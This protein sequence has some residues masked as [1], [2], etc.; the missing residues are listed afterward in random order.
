LYAAVFRTGAVA[1]AAA[2]E[3]AAE[4]RE[5]CNADETEVRKE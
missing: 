1:V 4:A 2:D 5:S 3:T